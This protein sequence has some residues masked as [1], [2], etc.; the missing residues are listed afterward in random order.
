[1]KIFLIIYDEELLR[2]AEEFYDLKIS[3]Y[4]ITTVSEESNSL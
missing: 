3:E 4:K 1:M 2:Y